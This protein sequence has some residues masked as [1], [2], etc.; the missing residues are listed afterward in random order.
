M[1]NLIKKSGEIFDFFLHEFQPR[2]LQLTFFI[3]IT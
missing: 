3:D 1:C 2:D